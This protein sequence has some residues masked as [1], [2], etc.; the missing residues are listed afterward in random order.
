MQL[1]ESARELILSG[2]I[3]H[4]V[5][6]NPDGGPQVSN[7]WVDVD[8]D[9]LISGH[10]GE[11]RKIT[12]IRRDPRVA[13]SFTAP[14]PMPNGMHPNLVLYGTAEIL[15]G[16]APELVPRLALRY[17]APDFDYPVPEGRP[18]GFTIRTTIRR[19]AGVGP[20]IS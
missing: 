18:A 2:A 4:M 8:G 14:E 1:P 19:I 15:E 17:V 9:D 3:A 11:Y 5:T 12:N 6:I 7:I 20:W 16:G 13:Y 10:F